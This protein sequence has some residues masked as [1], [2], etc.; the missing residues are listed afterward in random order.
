MQVVFG[1]ATM[2]RNGTRGLP[3]HVLDQSSGVSE[4][5][6]WTKFRSRSRHGF[7]T[8]RWSLRETYGFQ[9]IQ[10]RLM[11]ALYARVVEGFVLAAFQTGADGPQVFCERRCA[12]SDAS[13]ATA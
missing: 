12:E 11:D 2:K 9:R 1:I 3:Q 13:G 8:R 4:T 10:C 7:H 5:S 6:V